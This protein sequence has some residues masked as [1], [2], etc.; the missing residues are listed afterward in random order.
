MIYAI[1]GSFASVFMLAKDYDN[2]DI[3]ITFAAA[4]LFALGLQPF[5]ADHMDRSQGI[6]IISAS[7][8]L[9]LLMML[10][11]AGLFIFAGGTTLLASALVIILAIHAVMQPLLNTLAFRLSESGVG[12]S[13]GVG[14]AGGSLGY[15][16]ILAVLG[17][18][19]ERKGV[20]VLPVFTEAACALLIALLFVTKKSFVKI[21]SE[22]A[23][24]DARAEEEADRKETER[25]D[26]VSFIR[27]NRY[28]FILNLGVAGL[29]FS[30]AVLSN[31]M[32]QIAGNVGG[33]TGDVGHIL[34]LMAL[35]EIPTMVFFDKIRKR[36]S[37]RT[38]IKTAAVGFTLKIAVCWLAGSVRV[39]LAA[40]VFQLAAFAL[41][42][43]SM[44]YFINEIMSPGEAVRGQALFTTM[45]TVTTIFSSLLGGWILDVS[46]A[47]ML[48]F[49]A[50]L[51][52]AA[53]AVI[54]FA[55]VDR[56][57]K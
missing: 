55:V 38:L 6:Q 26:L 52:T 29:L 23:S 27:R 8:R 40:Q 56:I 18:I 51:A 4:N 49:I 32:P 7:S 45:I 3:G 34:S 22:T 30:N 46:G 5:V 39:L 37:S 44:V 28:F 9:T 20:D 53:G 25:I 42:M 24:S 10:A 47:K 17:T 2:T 19:V 54:V 11:G 12:V 15:S 35:L 1:A 43:P 21:Q 14:R 48:T 50:T 33:T 57:R 36:F 31:Y 41:L 16:A 13:F